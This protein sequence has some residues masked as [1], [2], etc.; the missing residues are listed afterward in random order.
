MKSEYFE[1]KRK[2]SL[3]KKILI[4]FL[5]LIFIGG[6]TLGILLYGPYSGLVNYSFYDINDTSMDCRTFL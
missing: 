6:S 3:W 1:K 2:K 5:I 4:V